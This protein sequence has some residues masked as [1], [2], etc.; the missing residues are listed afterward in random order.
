M[1]SGLN[2][3]KQEIPFD[4]GIKKKI[5]GPKNLSSVTEVNEDEKVKEVE[6]PITLSENNDLD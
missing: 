5:K 1:L 6:E 3:S 2:S 4:S